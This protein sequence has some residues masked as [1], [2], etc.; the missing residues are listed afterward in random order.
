MDKPPSGAHW[1]PYPRPPSPPFP[2]GL[3]PPPPPA[4]A[5]AHH[6][7][8][9]SDT[10]Q[11][12]VRFRAMRRKLPRF[13]APT[14]QRAIR[15][16]QKRQFLRK[17]AKAAK[18]AGL[19]WRKVQWPNALPQL[20]LASKQL[21][22]MHRRYLAKLYRMRLRP[23][24]K[25][26]LEEKL[27]A[28]TLF[29]GKKS[30]YD[31]S[32]VRR[33]WVAR[34][35]GSRR[36]GT[37]E[38]LTAARDAPV[39]HVRSDSTRPGE[40]KQTHIRVSTP[41]AGE[42]WV[43]STHPKWRNIG[44]SSPGGVGEIVAS[45]MGLKRN[46]GNLKLQ[47]RGFV[48]TTEVR[49]CGH[50]VP[51]RARTGVH[52]CGCSDHQGGPARWWSG[53]LDQALYVVMDKS[54]ALK[55]RIPLSDITGIEVSTLADGVIVVRRENEPTPDGDLLMVDPTG[56]NLVRQEP[57]PPP[58]Q[59]AKLARADDRP[60]R[61]HTAATL[62]APTGERA[63]RGVHRSGL[64]RGCT[65]RSRRRPARRSA[66]SSAKASR[67]TPAR[68]SARS[69]LSRAPRPWASSSSPRRAPRRMRSACSRPTAW[70]PRRS[71]HPAAPRGANLKGGVGCA[72]LAQ[73]F[74][75]P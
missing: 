74:G 75:G 4:A 44:A 15:T 46:C 33:A 41:F 73:P 59:R 53:T 67:S 68:C 42:L 35:R 52:A 11:A 39:E 54:L 9:T 23:D 29:K 48:L 22:E 70:R 26:M 37:E 30:T 7:R 16:W 58:P 17:L 50:A 32:Y 24:R 40:N 19:N 55:R 71:S 6:A 20:Q 56:T 5:T 49:S 2:P 66:L 72:A 51:S 38:G 62:W 13:A 1:P 61:P 27:E 10:V 28:S 47:P 43:V 65:A 36:A 63:R 34:K 14:V 3:T 25:A 8:A 12:R 64:R 69:R 57:L 31:A 60:P 45:F 21:K 18:A